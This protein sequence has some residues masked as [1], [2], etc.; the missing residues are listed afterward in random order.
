VASV[1]TSELPR[2]AVA[3]ATSDDERCSESEALWKVGCELIGIPNLAM[4]RFESL[5]ATR[6]SIDLGDHLAAD[7]A[8]LDRTLR[9]EL[10]KEG[11]DRY[12]MDWPVSA[13]RTRRRIR[14][15]IPNAEH[16]QQTPPHRRHL[17]CRRSQRA[18]TSLAPGEL[19]LPH[20][21]K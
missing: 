15:A 20:E 12:R 18:C 1:G 10:Q 21:P 13:T 3:I 17:S 6:H 11:C 5:S 2:Y 14:V 8:Q 16:A 9:H 4:L 19:S 7:V